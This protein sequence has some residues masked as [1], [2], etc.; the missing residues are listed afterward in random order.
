MPHATGK[1]AAGLLKDQQLEILNGALL[2]QSAWKA[3]HPESL[4]ALPPEKWTELVSPSLRRGA[5]VTCDNTAVDAD[6]YRD[7]FEFVNDPWNRLR[8]MTVL[9]TGGFELTVRV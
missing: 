4:I 8:T 2:P 7:Y 3:Q 9:F 6:E 5:I 1:A